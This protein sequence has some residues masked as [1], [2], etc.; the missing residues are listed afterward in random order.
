[1]DTYIFTPHHKNPRFKWHQILA[2]IA[3]LVEQ[4]NL[5]PDTIYQL[6]VRTLDTDVRNGFEELRDF[7]TTTR[8]L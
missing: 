7:G 8:N 2:F 3:N 5:G 1:M 4:Y 6:M